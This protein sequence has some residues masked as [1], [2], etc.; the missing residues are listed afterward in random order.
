MSLKE[1]MEKDNLNQEFLNHIS[2]KITNGELGGELNKFN[3][4]NGCTTFKWNIAILFDDPEEFDDDTFK[5][6]DVTR[7][8]VAHLV[9]QGILASLEPSFTLVLEEI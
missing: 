4:G 9:E 6:M 2:K 7:K 3:C 1:K 8:E 5:S